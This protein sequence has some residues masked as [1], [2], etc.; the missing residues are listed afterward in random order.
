[1][2]EAGPGEPVGRAR[3]ARLRGLVAD[4]SPLRHD[5]DYRYLFAGQTVSNIGAQITRIA[6][7]YQVFV[8]TG[9]T[10]A[11]G[12]LTAVQLVPILLFA[13]GAGSVADAVDR[14]KLL[15]LT[16][17]ALAVTSIALAVLA[18]QPSPPL[19]PILVLAF[20][21]AGF[22][23]IDQPARSSA[24]PRLVPPERLPAAIALGQLNFHVSAVVGPAIGGVL[25]ATVGLA[26]AYA[27]DSV[28]F[29]AAISALLL[30][31]PLPPLAGAARPGLAAIREGIRFALD[32]RLILST[33]VIDLNAMIFGMPMALFPVMALEVF[34]VGPEGLG[35]LAAAPGLGG[36]LGA[37]LSGWVGRVERTG[38]AVVWAVVVWGLAIAAFG[39]V[40]FSF[41]LALAFLALAGA[42]DVLSAVFRATIV[43]LETPDELRGRVT[44]LHILVVTSGPRVGDLEAAALASVVGAQASV[45]SGG[46]LCVLGVVA[47]VRFFPELMA[48]RQ[49]RPREAPAPA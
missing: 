4:I 11:V 34:R 8:L 20:L 23:A 2:T 12:L 46:L 31:R 32:R 1:V 27:V 41:A 42:A 30:I 13:L 17:A 3:G 36:F 25:I 15:L 38:S 7:P 43:Q 33:F 24:L 9:S 35:L 6:L 19:V 28:S 45:V 22:S 5:R 48:H 21:G 39:L 18:L 49:V 29:V 44:S 26:G 40:T 10:L 14:R 37:F 16:Q 47:V